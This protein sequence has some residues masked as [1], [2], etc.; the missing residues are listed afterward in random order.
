M[1]RISYLIKLSA[2]L[3]LASFSVPVDAQQFHREGTHK[4]RLRVPFAASAAPHVKR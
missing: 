2:L 3:G 4:L 1:Q